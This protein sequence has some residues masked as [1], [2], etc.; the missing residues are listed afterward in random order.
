MYSDKGSQM[1]YTPFFNTHFEFGHICLLF[2][3]PEQSVIELQYVAGASGS[4]AG[5]RVLPDNIEFT[6][7]D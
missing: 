7:L 5:L 4:R 1:G 2:S 6:K 3:K